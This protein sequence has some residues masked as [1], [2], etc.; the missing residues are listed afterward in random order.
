MEEKNP[1]DLSKALA[2]AS[3]ERLNPEVSKFRL[4][5]DLTPA[6]DQE[7]AI[8]E[9]ILQLENNQEIIEMTNEM[10]QKLY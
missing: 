7:N 9:L 1:F 8:E 2:G 5:T 10:R 6:G 4:N 3:V